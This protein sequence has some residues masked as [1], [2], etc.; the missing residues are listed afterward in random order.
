MHGAL[1]RLYYGNLRLVPRPHLRYVGTGLVRR[2]ATLA[3]S[4]LDHGRSARLS[5]VTAS[6]QGTRL[7]RSQRAL[8]DMISLSYYIA[9]ESLS[10]LHVSVICVYIEEESIKAVAVFPFDDRVSFSSRGS[11]SLSSSLRQQDSYGVS[12][13][14]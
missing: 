11:D 2:V 5:Y 12:A 7:Y 14:N 13:L 8:H 3:A 10:R 6:M 1:A 9:I 4:R